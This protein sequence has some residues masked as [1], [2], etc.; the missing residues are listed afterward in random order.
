MKIKPVKNTLFDTLNW[1]LK[2]KKQKP[3]EIFEFGFLLN[4]W[5]SMTTPENAKIINATGNRWCKVPSFISLDKIYYAFISKFSDK[6]SYIKKTTLPKEED[7]IKEYAQNTERSIK[8]IL[9]LEKALEE[10][11]NSSK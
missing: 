9:F 6:I 1:I 2:T 7:D 10:I 3:T 8:D 4:R 11:N 5:L